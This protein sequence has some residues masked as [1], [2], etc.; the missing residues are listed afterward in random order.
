MSWIYTH[1]SVDLNL[2]VYKYWHIG[3]LI[4]FAFAFFFMLETQM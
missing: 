4:R 3:E 2:P 1:Q